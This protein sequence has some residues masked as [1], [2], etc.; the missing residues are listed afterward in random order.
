MAIVTYEGNSFAANAG[1]TVLECL[2]RHGIDVPSFCRNGACQTCLMRATAGTPPP[3]AQQGLKPALKNQGLLL[4]CVCSTDSDIAVAPADAARSYES[5][6][7]SVEAVSPRVRRVVLERPQDLEFNAGQFLQVTRAEDGTTRPYSIA[8][9]PTDATLELHVAVQDNGAL[10]PW[11][12]RAV[13]ARVSLR[14]PFGECS[15]DA[16]EPDA[17]LILAATGTGLAP[18][19]GVLRS[20]LATSHRGT[21]RL[22]HAAASQAELYY[23]AQLRELVARNTNLSLIEITPDPEAPREASGAAAASF[24]RV[25][26][27]S[28]DATTHV[29]QD[30]PSPAAL[31]AYV[32]GNPAFVQQVKRSLYLK[33][34]SLA[35]IHSDPFFAKAK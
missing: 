20:A 23:S 22:T 9:L 11:F 4:A 34:A 6:V 31:R 3:R 10:S 32:C 28:G 19:W 17:P 29:L 33:G 14:G 21:I 26:S 5:R 25:R 1:E 8:S 27:A 18:I 2:E 35:R 30:L 12:E 24:E 13:G 15:Y 16:S 7:V